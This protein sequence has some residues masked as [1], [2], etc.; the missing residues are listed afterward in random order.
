MDRWLSQKGNHCFPMI[1]QDL[2]P[3]LLIFGHGCIT[4]F[5]PPNYSPMDSARPNPVCCD[6]CLWSRVRHPVLKRTPVSSSVDSN[7]RDNALSGSWWYFCLFLFFFFVQVLPVRDISLCLCKDNQ[8]AMQCVPH[9]DTPVHCV[10]GQ[11]VTLRYLAV[12]VGVII[13]CCI[14]NSSLPDCSIC[15]GRAKC[16]GRCLLTRKSRRSGLS[17]HRCSLP[18]SLFWNAW[19]Q[20]VAFL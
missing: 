14:P 20:Q 7:T 12:R 9:Q 1:L 4:G 18:V 16:L 3:F 10:M 17:S 15:S 11:N 13:S 2:N 19:D 6:G 5:A 8:T